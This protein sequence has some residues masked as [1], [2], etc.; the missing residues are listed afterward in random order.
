MSKLTNTTPEPY[1][2][3]YALGY[4]SGTQYKAKY[5][6]AAAMD[7]AFND[8]PSMPTQEDIHFWRGWLRA[9]VED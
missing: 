6:R 2:A 4:E 1:K 5:N 7:K 3:D 9:I 8:K